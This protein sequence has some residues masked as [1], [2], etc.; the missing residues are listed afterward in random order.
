MNKL[1]FCF[2]IVSFLSVSCAHRDVMKYEEP[3]YLVIE[4]KGKFEIRQYE[5]YIVAAT[6]VEGDFDKVGNEGFRRLFK[7]IQGNNQSK[8]SISMTAPVS[9]EEKSEKIAMTAPVRQEETG[10]IWQ[11]S[12]VMP[13]KYSMDTLPDPLD[14][15][16][17]LRK[18]PGRL[19]AVIQYS[20]TWSKMRYERHEALLK[21]MIR[22]MGFS[23]IGRPVFARYN[24][25]FTPWFLRRNEIL[26]PVERIE[27]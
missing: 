4:K 13:S 25:P 11:I 3:E 10:D 18:V 6:F 7:Y 26:I 12:F 17:E 19:M 21:D 23:E 1:S 14:P 9:Q 16:V 27:Q 22:E 24:P 2:L 8:Q 20:G 15:S 5:P